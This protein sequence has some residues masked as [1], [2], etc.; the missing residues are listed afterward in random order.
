[1]NLTRL[2]GRASVAKRAALSACFLI[3]QQKVMFFKVRLKI[4]FCCV[5]GFTKLY[6][7]QNVQ[8]IQL[9]TPNDKSTRAHQGLEDV[10][11]I[12]F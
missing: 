8:K 4:V 2:Q 10:S 11:K 6:A 7:G 5:I 3:T 1:M 12:R 9:L